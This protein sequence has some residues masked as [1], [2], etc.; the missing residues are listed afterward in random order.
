M[1]IRRLTATAFLVLLLSGCA[2]S[3]ERWI[4]DTRVHQGDT[5]LAQGSVSEAELA[6]RLALK[7]DPTDPRARAGFSLVAADI[8]DTQFKAGKLDDALLTLATAS[9]YDPQSVRLQALRSE[10]ETAKIK[11]EIV[12]SNYPSFKETGSQIVRSYQ[13]LRLINQRIINSLKKF[14][15]TF[16]VGDLSSAIK[17]SYELNLEVAHNTNRL[18]AYRQVLEA[19]VP[20]AAAV[21]EPALAPPTSLLPLP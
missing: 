1:G 5:A 12:V 14:N 8:A 2:G 6:Y 18:L 17:Q 15:Y 4:V 13:A 16:N 19:G 10:I 3:V 7:V 20:G 9:T 21:S 11:R